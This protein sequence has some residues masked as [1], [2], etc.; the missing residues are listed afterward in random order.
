VGSPR[1]TFN[2]IDIDLPHLSAYRLRRDVAGATNTAD[3]GV[4][5][6]V[7]T[8]L[9]LGAELAVEDIPAGAVTR[10]LAA[11]W[12]WASAGETYTFAR[13][14]AKQV[15]TTIAMAVAPGATSI[16]VADATGLGASGTPY[17]L[18][19]VD[20]L[21]EEIVTVR[22]V[23][24]A[25]GEVSLTIGTSVKFAYAVGDV[26]RDPDFWPLVVNEDRERPFVENVS[27]LTYSM[28]HGFREAA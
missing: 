23:N 2:A 19:S 4:T 15:N 12:A 21:N 14:S 13:D 25:T 17:R 3:A 16:F 7:R 24:A 1:L 5:E 9:Y 26:V 6:R 8:G 22:L 18:R 11:W 20:G 28:R 27:G 10:G